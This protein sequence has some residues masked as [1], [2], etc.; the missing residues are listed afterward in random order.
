MFLFIRLYIYIR[1]LIR[2]NKCF[3]V[4][5]FFLENRSRIDK[6]KSWLADEESRQVYEGMIRFRQYRDRH[7]AY[8]E[9]EIYFVPGIISFNDNSIFIDCGAYNG[10]TIEQFIGKCNNYKKIYALEPNKENVIKIYK[11]INKNCWHNVEVI[12][13]ASWEC[14]KMLKFT[15]D[16]VTQTGN[17]ISNDGT[18]MIKANSIDNILKGTYCSLIK[19]DVEGAELK[20]LK[21]AKETILKYKPQLAI[22][23]YHSDEDMIDI[24]EYIHQLIPEHKLYIRHHTCNLGDTVL[25]AVP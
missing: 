2:Q 17:A 22:C 13:C 1:N 9:K 18:V 10:D 24:A 3:K 5:C 8:S 4:K 11:K 16:S 20:S 23:I 14:E 12:E 19:M 15:N 25:Y 6:V 21:G 7:P